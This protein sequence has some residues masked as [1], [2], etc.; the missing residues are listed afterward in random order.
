VCI[1]CV[2]GF[3]CVLKSGVA[4]Q[5]QVPRAWDEAALSSFELPLVNAGASAHHVSPDFYYR[6]PIRPIFKSYPIY[7]PGREPQGYRAWL[8]QQEPEI[9]FDASRLQSDADWIRAGE[10][11]FDAPVGYG[12]TFRL[13][14][15]RD[16]A[17]YERNQ[18]PVTRD[19]I[20]PF[21]RYVVRKKGTVEVG[22]G[23]CL[24]CHARV[25]PDGR[26]IK[27]AQG[28]FPADR[29]IAYNLRQQAA[30]AR[31][32]TEFLGAIRLGQ[33]TF[34]SMPWLR[35]DPVARIDSMSL[36][37][38]ATAYDAIPTGVTTRVNL[39]LFTPA[40]IPDL[41]GL[42]DRRHLDHTGIVLQRSIGDLMRYVA[43][44]QGANSFDRFGDFRLLDPLPDPGKVERYSDE[45][46][47][48]LARF[49]YS[50]K[51]PASPYR[52]DANA[53]R[54]QRIF[55]REGCEACHT[56]PL[57]TSNKL[58]PVAGFTVPAEHLE[59]YGIINR[60][61]GTDPALALRTRKGTGY[62][63]VPS[64]KGVWYRGP[65]Q[66]AGAA[67]T[68]EDWFNP[69]RLETIPGHPFGLGLNASDRRALIAFL[70]TL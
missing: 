7:E 27:G 12:A 28:N 58:T 15:V 2:L 43:L 11:V 51:P 21:S 53:A 42:Q 61:I 9:A 14:Q 22:S 18:V 17:W 60:V 6:I 25:M 55:S 24:M 3:L 49:L 36:E 44:V 46:L 38:I 54:G 26:L 29:V 59:R 40:Q 57:Y 30:D 37:D 34:F 64:L 8:E 19:G 5:P 20:M 66:H 52:F 31:N 4:A 56:P 48:A 62:Y 39:S 32:P 69:A 70:R 50:L 47:Y 35:P 16:R 33:R 67:K 68:L 45:Q 65:L 1:L 41:I 10:A 23:G 13:S 63:K